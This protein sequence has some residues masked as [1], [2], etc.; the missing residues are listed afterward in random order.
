MCGG[1]EAAKRLRDGGCDTMGKLY[2]YVRGSAVQ[3]SSS[4]SSLAGCGDYASPKK[5][6]ARTKKLRRLVNDGDLATK[7]A[8]LLLR[9]MSAFEELR[10]RT[11]LCLVVR[12]TRSHAGGREAAGRTMSQQMIMAPW[13]FNRR[14]GPSGTMLAHSVARATRNGIRSFGRTIP[15][16]YKYTSSASAPPG[17]TRLVSINPIILNV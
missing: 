2:T 6:R 5:A 10:V 12:F 3:C 14:T 1:K 16:M 15:F 13:W 7:I 11:G 4:S 9:L 8:S 17:V